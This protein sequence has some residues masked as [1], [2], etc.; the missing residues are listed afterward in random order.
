[1]E[2]TVKWFN[3][4]KGYG[5]IEGSDGTDYFAHF[6][7]IQVEGYKTLKEGSAVTFEPGDGE[8]GP[9]AKNIQKDE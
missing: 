7:E 6:Q 5:F 9:V 3:G 1:M 4:S 8:K 2:G